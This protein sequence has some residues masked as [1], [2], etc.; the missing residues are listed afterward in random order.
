[1]PVVRAGEIDINYRIAG[2]GRE[3]VMLVNGLGDGLDAWAPQVDDFVD[4][5]MSELLCQICTSL[6]A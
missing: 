1:M 5:G 2:D 6:P 3:T 4:A